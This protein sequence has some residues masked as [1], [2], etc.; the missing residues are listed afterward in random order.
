MFAAVRI[1][2]IYESYHLA[3]LAMEDM[4]RAGSCLKFFEK[5]AQPV[6]MCTHSNKDKGLNKILTQSL[7]NLKTMLMNL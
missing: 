3:R 5:V 6:G 7:S 2:W 4:L 1:T